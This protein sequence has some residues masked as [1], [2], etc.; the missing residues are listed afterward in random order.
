M[1]ETKSTDTAGHRLALLAL[2]I[3]A[4][5]IG[6]SEFSSMGVLQ[7]FARDLAIDIPHAT[8]A[9][10]AYAIGVVAGAPLLTLAAARVN[11]RLLLILLMGI[12]VA[13]NLLSSFADSLGLLVFGRFVSGLPQGAYFGAGAVVATYIVGPA[14]A[15]KAFALVVSGMTVATIVGAP[16]G[17]LVG[18]HLGW[19]TSYA[20]FAAYNLLALV[21]M[22]LWLPKT[23]AL[24][25]NPILRELAG[26]RRWNVWAM[27]LVAALCVAS[28]FAV[29][30]FVGPFVT[31]VAGLSPGWV[32]VGL[33]LFGLGMA[34]GN[35]LGGR[36]ADRYE[37][38]GMVI[39]FGATLSV[40]CVM[41]LFGSSPVV[42]MTT[43]FLV[44]AS[45]MMAVPT[46]PVRM[47]EMAPEAPTLMGAMNMA[48]FNVANALGA[49]AGGLTIGA[50]LG[51]PSAI[52]AGFSL[53]GLGLIVF[54]LS[55]ARLR[56]PRTLAV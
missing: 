49:A 44:G 25:G 33:G 4:F 37:F 23:A 47:T 15:G 10:T 12:L 54:A 26:L 32:P 53:T 51:L 50:G 27:M 34:V 13:G 55:F 1:I 22:M 56:T 7:L 5:G 43:L 9:I 48:A 29:Y 46:I 19:R 3:G 31:Q 40:L 41:A 38:R 16:L 39:G 42:L 45:L 6:T 18:Q 8:E 28:T 21:A 17:T 2:A 30:T 35:P 52:W 11:R 24:D 36:L 20:A 14:R